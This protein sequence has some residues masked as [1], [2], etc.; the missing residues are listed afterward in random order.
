MLI[1]FTLLKAK[2]HN[3]LHLMPTDYEITVGKL[4]NYLSDDQICAILSSDNYSD[5]NKI[6][7]GCLIERMNQ[8][9]E[10]L[11]LCDQLENISGSRDL[12][13]IISEIRSGKWL[14]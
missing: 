2:Y 14:L 11:D 6:I 10:L 1:E 5:A 3:I 9:E 12:C 4:Q 13:K 7:L 8:K